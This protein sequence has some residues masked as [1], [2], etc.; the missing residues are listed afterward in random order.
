MQIED[1]FSLF[2][3]KT[4]LEKNRKKCCARRLNL[5]DITVSLMSI[6]SREYLKSHGQQF[7][8]KSNFPLHFHPLRES[9]VK[10]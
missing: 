4:E 8:F 10:I 5:I 9:L 1:S 3:V 2:Y 7:Q 6:K